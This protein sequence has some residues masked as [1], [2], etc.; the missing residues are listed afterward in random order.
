MINRPAATGTLVAGLALLVAM[1]C[2][3]RREFAKAQSMYDSAHYGDA[4][5]AFEPIAA[6]SGEWAEK[7][8]LYLGF[9]YFKMGRHEQA[10][11]S[12]EA[13]PERFPD[14][15][16]ADDAWYWAGRCSEDWGRASDA[17]VAYEKALATIPP[18]GKA[19]MALRAREE[20]DM[21]EAA[22]SAAPAD[23][24]GVRETTDRE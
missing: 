23:T 4:L 3:Q 13:L 10:I 18:S 17:A 12:F 24:T 14:S 6:G 16:L 20:L 2:G 22:P 9:S 8:Q 15:E 5:R 7:A 11:R 1:S 21:L 19:N